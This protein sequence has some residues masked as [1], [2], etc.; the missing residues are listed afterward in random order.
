[1][2]KHKTNNIFVFF[3]EVFTVYFETLAEKKTGGSLQIRKDNALAEPGVNTRRFK[4]QVWKGLE[5]LHI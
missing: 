1:M 5:S 4:K 2:N 3:F